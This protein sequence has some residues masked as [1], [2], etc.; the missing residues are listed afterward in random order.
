MTEEENKKLRALFDE[1][2]ARHR[3]E[4]PDNPVFLLR[5]AF[6]AMGIPHTTDT[7]WPTRKKIGIEDERV[8]FIF[9]EQGKFVA[10]DID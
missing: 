10:L 4:T 8:K 1:W 3:P 2:E 6:D 9:D 5:R 7:S